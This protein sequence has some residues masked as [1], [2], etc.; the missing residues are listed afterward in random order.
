MPRI[1]FIVHSVAINARD[2]VQ[3][4]NLVQVFGLPT[5]LAPELGFDVLGHCLLE[6]RQTV[7]QPQRRE[8]VAVDRKVGA[9]QLVVEATGAGASPGLPQQSTLIAMRTRQLEVHVDV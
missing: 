1:G 3:D 6:L 9:P 7:S 2:A 5:D 8:I 4:L